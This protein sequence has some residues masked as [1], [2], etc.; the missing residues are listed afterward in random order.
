LSRKS[1]RHYFCFPQHS[2]FVLAHC[3]VCFDSCA[4][5]VDGE[6]DNILECHPDDRRQN[7]VL[8]YT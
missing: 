8:C 2:Q 5:L 3:E 1:I 4:S 7:S 6:A